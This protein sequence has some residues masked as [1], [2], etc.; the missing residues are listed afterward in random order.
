MMEPVLTAVK[1]ISVE[2]LFNSKLLPSEDL[3]VKPVVR[4]R[5]NELLVRYDREY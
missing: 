1:Q 3:N 4:V 2:P 5:L